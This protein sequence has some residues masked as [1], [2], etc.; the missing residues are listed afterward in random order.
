MALR[1]RCSQTGCSVV[2]ISEAAVTEGT[3]TRVGQRGI[4]GDPK[5]TEPQQESVLNHAGKDFSGHITALLL[6][7]IHLFPLTN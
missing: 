2:K 4:V 6:L 7:I 5:T 3:C 1:E